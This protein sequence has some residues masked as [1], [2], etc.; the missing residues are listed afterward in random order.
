MVALVSLTGSALVWITAASSGGCVAANFIQP[1]VKNMRLTQPS[2]PLVSLS[3]GR[4]CWI[5]LIVFP[6]GGPPDRMF[7]SF[8]SMHACQ[9]IMLHSGLNEPCRS[10]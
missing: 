7:Q 4:L 6:A 3:R 10:S 2:S 9:R 5:K 8:V 1:D